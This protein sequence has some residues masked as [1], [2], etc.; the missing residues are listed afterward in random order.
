M[1]T[2]SMAELVLKQ[3][4]GCFL[5]RLQL[6]KEFIFLIFKEFNQFDFDLDEFKSS[7]FFGIFKF[8]QD[9]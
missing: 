3:I 5:T 7:I 4:F 6:F 9:Y 2:G 8:S 1:L